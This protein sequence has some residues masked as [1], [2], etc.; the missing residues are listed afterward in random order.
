VELVLHNRHSLA[1]PHGKGN[2]PY[3]SVCIC[4]NCGTKREVLRFIGAKREIGHVKH[5]RCVKCKQDTKHTESGE[6]GERT[7]AEVYQETYEQMGSP[8]NGDG[9]PQP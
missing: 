5:L 2:R 9:Y 7:L 1:R 8:A 3:P 4:E 6:T